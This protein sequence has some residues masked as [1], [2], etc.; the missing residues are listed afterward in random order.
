MNNQRREGSIADLERDLAEL[1]NIAVDLSGGVVDRVV[2]VSISD[3]SVTLFAERAPK[4]QIAGEIDEFKDV[5]G[6]HAATLG[7]YFVDITRTSRRAVNKPELNAGDGLH[8]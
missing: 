6:A 2:L 5:L 7:T 3:S 8:P 4:Q 1:T